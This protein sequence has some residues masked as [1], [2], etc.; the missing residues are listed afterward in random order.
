MDGQRCRANHSNDQNLVEGSNKIKR[1]YT[2]QSGNTGADSVIVTLDTKPPVVVIT[3]PVNGFVTNKTPVAVAWSVDGVAQTTQLTQALT[4]GVNTITRSA[5]DAA[6]NV[7][8]ASITVTLDTKP[9]VVVITSP[10]NGLLTNKTPVAVAWSVDGVAQTTQ[11]TQALT[12][13]VNTITRSA[14]D[15]AGNVGIASIT[16]TLDTKPPV[17]VITSPANGLLTN[18]T[19]VAV[20]WSVDGVAQTT[21][22]TQALAEGIN[23]ITRT[24]TDAAGNVGT[25]SITVTLDTK[26][27]VVVI[28]SPANGFVTNKTPVA[29][30][31]MVDGVAQTTQLSAN[32][33]EGAK[34]DHP[35]CD[36]CS[37]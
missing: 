26:P 35:H 30:A 37:G 36:R 34:H 12:E 23:T 8:T 2:D 27:P 28:T 29:V 22:L 5:T 19:P 16:V 3:S 17:V 20:A 9:P 7:G 4:E 24:A 21:Q 15:A 11:L 1:S 18:K 10:A 31:W 25:A 13:G 6:G 32:L 14:T 33:V